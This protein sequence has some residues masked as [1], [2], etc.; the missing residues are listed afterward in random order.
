MNEP[1]PALPESRYGSAR[2]T[3]SRPWARWVFIAVALAASV[4][5]AYVAYLNFGSTPIT[6]ERV[7]FEELPGNSME[8][9]IDVQRDAPERPGVCIV[10]V[11]DESGAESGRKEVFVPPG[12]AGVRLRTVIR[13][14]TRP[15]TADVFGCSYSVPDYLSR[16]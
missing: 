10:R 15:V 8:I 1:A 5:A 11:R 16:P 4:A 13:S 7:A 2:T 14:G 9:T 6:A 3:P 12:E